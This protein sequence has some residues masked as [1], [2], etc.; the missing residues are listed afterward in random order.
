MEMALVNYFDEPE[1]TKEI[2][3]FATEFLLTAIEE[4]TSHIHPDVMFVGDDWG[5]ARSTFLSPD[6]HEEFFLGPYTKIHAK[7][8]EC[9]VQFIVKHSDSY[10]ASLIPMMIECGIDVYQACLTTNNTPELIAKYGDQITFMGDIDNQEIDVP[11]WSEEKVEV[12][13]RRA[14]ERCGTEHFIPCL[15]S[16]M[17]HSV[18]PG[19]YESVTKAIEKVNQ[20]K[21]GIS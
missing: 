15:C 9:G 20:E 12:A 6:M 21:F 7:A 1:C 10:C 18:Y 5:S 19:V 8:K 2:I 11:D 14:C 4:I 13:V 16:G 17:P 3:D